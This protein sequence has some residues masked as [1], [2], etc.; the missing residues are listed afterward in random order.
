M[1]RKITKTKTDKTTLT[2]NHLEILEIQKMQLARKEQ[3]LRF[4]AANVDRLHEPMYER[5]EESKVGYANR[6]HLDLWRG[7]SIDFDMKS[8]GHSDSVYEMVMKEM[9]QKAVSENEA[10]LKEVA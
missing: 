7:N 2:A 5:A 4:I 6:S 1:N 3:E 8:T 9:Y 10:Y